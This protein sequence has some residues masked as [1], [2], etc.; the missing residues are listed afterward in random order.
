MYG[1]APYIKNGMPFDDMP[2]LSRLNLYRSGR[3]G[4]P[5]LRAAALSSL[6]ALAAF[7]PSGSQTANA[8]QTLPPPA[9]VR[10]R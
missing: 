7:S 3:W 5:R 9:L 10:V 4:A 2:F 8:F 6:P 1:G